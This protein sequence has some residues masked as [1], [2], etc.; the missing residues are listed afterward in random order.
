LAIIRPERISTGHG[1]LEGPWW[2][3]GLGL[4]VA[5]A[6]LGGVL[7]LRPDGVQVTVIAHRRGIGGLALHEDGGILVGGRNLAIKRLMGE[8]DDASVVLLQN[9]PENHLKGF[10]DFTVD[11]AGRVYIGSL[12]FIATE[13]RS[14]RTGQLYLVDLD[15]RARIVA[16]DIQLSNGLGF[17][18]D[19]RT[20]YHADSLRKVVYAYEVGATGDLGPRRIFM[21]STEA[22]PDGLA[23]DAGGTVWI[24]M[25]YSGQVVGYTPEGAPCGAIEIDEPMVTS[26][27]FGG[28]DLKDLYIVSGSEG[29]KTD[30]GG[31][32]YRGRAAVPGLPR[33]RAK[34]AY[35]RSS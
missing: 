4:L 26:L 30:R 7:L 22:M 13:A 23:V 10:N 1:V 21:S 28:S 12:A 24:A 17:S 11:T 6:T 20:L 3:P 34:I 19:G 14:G 16:D 29:L 5:D 9:D 18:P 2:E 8:G 33:H 27:C 35:R 25:P 31:S 32:I 15:G